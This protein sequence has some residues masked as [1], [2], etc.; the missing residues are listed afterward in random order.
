MSVEGVIALLSLCLACISLG[1][2][3]GRDIKDTK[4]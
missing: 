4:K 1:Y 3:I 2:M